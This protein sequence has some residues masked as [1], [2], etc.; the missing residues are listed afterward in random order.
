MKKKHKII[1]IHSKEYV[2]EQDAYGYDITLLYIIENRLIKED[3]YYIDL[4]NKKVSQW[5]M[6]TGIHKNK[7]TWCD[8]IIAS[9]DPKLT[10]QNAWVGSIGYLGI[11]NIPNEIVTKY[12]K[13]PTKEI[14]V[15]YGYKIDKSQGHF[16]QIRR[17]FVK[18]KDNYIIC[19]LKDDWNDILNEFVNSTGDFV[20]F[21]DDRLESW[22]KENY[23][24]PTKK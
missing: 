16:H 6:G 24:P 21:L 8:V 15:E 23:N 3:E 4:V 22:L 20:V 18:S 11:L 12:N 13:N 9:N 19:Y 17:Y 5:K 10:L 14:E 1:S 2:D 7:S